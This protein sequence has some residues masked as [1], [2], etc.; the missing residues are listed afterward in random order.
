V[1]VISGTGVLVDLAVELAARV[2]EARGGITV[3]V[4]ARNSFVGDGPQAVNKNKTQSRKIG[5]GR[6]KR[7]ELILHIIVI[8][9]DV[10]FIWINMWLERQLSV[11]RRSG[12]KF[13]SDYNLLQERWASPAYLSCFEEPGGSL[14]NQVLSLLTRCNWKG[15]P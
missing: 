2:G 12:T 9:Q 11:E 3:L 14:G 7:L 6:K 13:R 5:M 10:R 15:L 8:L 1:G 4:G